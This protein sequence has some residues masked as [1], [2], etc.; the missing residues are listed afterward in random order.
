MKRCAFVGD[1]SNDLWIAR[2]AGFT[3]AFNPRCD[4]LEKEA[5]AIVRSEDF[6]DVLPHLLDGAS[7]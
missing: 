4:N 2:T 3:V 1:S 7:C 6:R 5:D